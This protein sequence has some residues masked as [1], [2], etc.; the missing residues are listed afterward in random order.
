MFMVSV[1]GRFFSGWPCKASF[2]LCAFKD[3][4]DINKKSRPVKFDV[5]GLHMHV[6]A[7]KLEEV[8]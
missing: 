1:L 7:C 5:L 3:L 4:Y 2:H 8:E 6:D